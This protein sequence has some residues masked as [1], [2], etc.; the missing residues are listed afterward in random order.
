M[1]EDIKVNIVDD[2][3]HK[4]RWGLPSVLYRKEGNKYSLNYR[5][6]AGL[7]GSFML[8]GTGYTLTS[9]FFKP[10]P[11]ENSQ[12]IGFNEQLDNNQKIQ[13][14]VGNSETTT[15][16]NSKAKSKAATIYTGLQVI[17][18]PNQ[19]RIPAGTF[20]KAK[21]ITGASNGPLKAILIEPLII[22]GEEIVP[23]GTSLVGIGSSGED[24]LTVQFTKMVFQN[25]KSQN[26]QGIACDLSDQTAGVKGKK[27]S[28]YALMLATS[29]GLNFL[30]GMAEGLQ[31]SQNENGVITKKADLKNAALHGASK[32]ALDQS[33]ETLNDIRNKKSVVQVES[34]QE[35][36]ILFEGD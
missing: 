5:V 34:G 1:S 24:R 26:I 15:P 8:M 23:A 20:V 14:P 36:Y 30:S 12:P 19:G 7:F 28:K 3:G 31:E 32:A 11:S 35:F 17:E 33:Q 25:G 18:R 6:A 4:R 10:T 16:A 22:E 21:F 9:D 29:A 2:N 13:V 27:V